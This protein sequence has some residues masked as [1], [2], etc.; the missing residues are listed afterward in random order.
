MI[1]RKANYDMVLFDLDGTLTNS[2]PGIVG[3]VK[4]ALTKMNFPI[5]EQETLRRFI[6][7]PLWHS[8]SEFC[9][10]T[11]EQ[12]E[13]A[14]CLYRDTYN[15]SGAFLNRPYPGVV[16]LL[17]MLKETCIPI[18][19][20]TSK[21]DNITAPVLDYFHL[22]PYFAYVSAPSETEHSSKK[23]EL[24]LTALEKCGVAP[25]RAVMVGDTHYDAV[26]AREAGTNF[27]GVLYGFGTR[28]EME[29]EGAVNF[30]AD[31]AELQSMLIR[32]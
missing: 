25:E 12:A 22:T 31:L 9:G 32:E 28:E 10:M 18:A 2:E 14:V 16:S 21:P 30:A 11:D 20:A 27:I 29:N 24:I 13:E 4:L 1:M 17:D 5:P 15:V 8:F 7:P 26:G 19:V 3:C 23:K 6:G